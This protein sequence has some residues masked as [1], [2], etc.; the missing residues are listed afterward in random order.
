[1]VMGHTG[2]SAHAQGTPTGRPSLTLMVL[3]V[4]TLWAQASVS[5]CSGGFNPLSPPRYSAVDGGAGP[6]GGAASR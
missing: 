5:A 2:R 3:V 6:D 4:V 1:M